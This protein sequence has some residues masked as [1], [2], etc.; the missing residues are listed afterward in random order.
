MVNKRYDSNFLPSTKESQGYKLQKESGRKDVLKRR[1]EG[2][3][4]K[5]W[6]FYCV[7]ILLICETSTCVSKLSCEIYTE[8]G[9]PES[10]HF[11]S[12]SNFV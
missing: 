12:C 11:I 6:D 4:L 1:Y 7:Y 5:L 8:E 3:S 10:I 9:F 2:F